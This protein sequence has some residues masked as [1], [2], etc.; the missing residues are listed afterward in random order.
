MFKFVYFRSFT[1]AERPASL[2]QINAVETE[3]VTCQ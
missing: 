1:T 3:N 2:V